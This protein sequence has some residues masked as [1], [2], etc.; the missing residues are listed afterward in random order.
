MVPTV[1]KTIP[2]PKAKNSARSRGI[3]GTD[4]VRDFFCI[5]QTL[6]FSNAFRMTAR[7]NPSGLSS[8]TTSLSHRPIKYYLR[9]SSWGNPSCWTLAMRSSSTGLLQVTNSLQTHET[10]FCLRPRNF[11][12]RKLLIGLK[13]IH[14]MSDIL[15]TKYGGI[16][17]SFFWQTDSGS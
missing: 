12:F 7:F 11:S 6:I 4:P 1:E 16:H 3:A 13:E 17:L 9:P 8:A 15:L 5:K 2:K 10:A 14:N